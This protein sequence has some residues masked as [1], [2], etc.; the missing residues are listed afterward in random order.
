SCALAAFGKLRQLAPSDPRGG[1]LYV[2][3]LFDANEVAELERIFLAQNQ[4]AQAR[5]TVDLDAATGLQQVYFKQGKWAQA[6]SWARKAA[7]AR[8]G[9]ADAQYRLGAFI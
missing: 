3:T 8:P 2:Q 7:D 6:L 5:G 9:D 1:Q 4:A